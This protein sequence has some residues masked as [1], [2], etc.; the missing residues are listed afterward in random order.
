VIPRINLFKQEVQLRLIH[1]QDLMQW[2]HSA[3]KKYGYSV[4]NINYIFCTDKYLLKLNKKYLGHNYF[5][6]VIT[7]NNSAEKKKLEADIFISI[8]R[9]RDN[10]K[11]YNT[12]F[13]DELHRVMIHGALHLAG[14]NDK[15]AVQ[16]KKMR[17]AEDLWLG[18]RKFLQ[19]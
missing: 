12:S 5:T 1:Q 10:A 8:D 15:N 19:K 14:F 4:E 13:T 11:K 18:K 3:L 9:I 7:F 16:Q 2:I 17:E 6:D